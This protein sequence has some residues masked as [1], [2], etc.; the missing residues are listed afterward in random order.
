MGKSNKSIKDKMIEIYGPECFIEKLHLRKDSGPRKYTGKNQMKRM[1]QLTYHHI[2]EKRN[3]GRATLENGALLSAENHAWFNKQ[4]PQAQEFMNTA[5]QEYKKRVKFAIN[6]AVIQ[7][8]EIPKAQSIEIDMSDCI[9]IPLE[10]NNRKYNR[11]KIKREFQK[12]VDEE[13][14]L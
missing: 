13:L 4:S 7:N 8:G 5:F 6:T 2:K 14:E 9:E 12:I 1:K 10:D 11:A 3:G